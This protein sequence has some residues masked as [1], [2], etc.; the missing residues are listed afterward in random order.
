[1]KVDILSDGLIVEPETDFEDSYIREMFRAQTE[2]IKCFIKCGMTPAQ[3]IGIKICLPPKTV[4]SMQSSEMGT[5]AKPASIVPNASAPDCLVSPVRETRPVSNKSQPETIT[6]CRSCK[7]KSCSSM[8]T[9]LIVNI[10]AGY[11]A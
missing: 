6:L 7:N 10:C 3:L 1:M 4:E 5:A 9:D 2:N 11:T 8:S